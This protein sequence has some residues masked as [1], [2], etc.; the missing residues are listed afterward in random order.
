MAGRRQA[1]ARLGE[2]IQ[3][4]QGFATRKGAEVDEGTGR[5]VAALVAA[6]QAQTE[7]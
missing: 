6:Y 3:N 4:N 2:K 7:I 1:P 5:L